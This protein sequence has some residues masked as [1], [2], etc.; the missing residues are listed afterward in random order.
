MMTSSRKT[1]DKRWTGAERWRVVLEASPCNASVLR[2]LLRRKGLHEGVGSVARGAAEAALAEPV[3]LSRGRAKLSP[4][5]QRIQVLERELRLKDAAPVK[6]AARL[7]LKH[8]A[9]DQ[10]RRAEELRASRRISTRNLL[11]NEQT[12]AR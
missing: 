1:T 4:E 3:K 11:P 12:E 5:T 9:G 2:A 6:T 10:R 8:S 7:V